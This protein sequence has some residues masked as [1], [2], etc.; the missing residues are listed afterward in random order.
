VTTDRERRRADLQRLKAE[1]EH[2]IAGQQRDVAV[3]ERHNA[4]M[5]AHEAETQ[6]LRAER[7]MQQ[8][9]QLANKSLFDV[10]GAIVTLPGA[11]EARRKIVSTTLDYL[12]NLSKD[13]HLDF[14][15]G[16]MT[17]D[18]YFFMAQVQGLPFRP[19]LGQPKE[20]LASL[21]K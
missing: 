2:K 6:R 8:L 19:N 15:L 17:A 21:A 11:T 18:G 12:D 16:R 7:R 10:Q 1:Q 9:L 3:R 14:E 5:Q 13:D 4:E 20:A